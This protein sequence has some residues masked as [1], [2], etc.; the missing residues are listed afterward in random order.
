MALVRRHRTGAQADA[1]A[2]PDR[3][4]Q[5]PCRRAHRRDRGGGYRRDDRGAVDFFVPI[6]QSN[7]DEIAR[8]PAGEFFE[9]LE[10][11][12]I[13]S[14][15]A[16]RI[17]RFRRCLEFDKGAR[18]RA[19]SIKRDIRPADA[20]IQKLR[21]N[22]QPLRY[23]QTR[24]QPLKQLLECRGERCLRNIRV[25]S[26]KLPNSVRV[27]LQEEDDAHGLLPPKLAARVIITQED[28]AIAEI[29]TLPFVICWGVSDWQR[30]STPSPKWAF[31][32]TS[33]LLVRAS[34]VRSGANPAVRL[35]FGRWPGWLRNP[36]FDP[37]D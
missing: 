10:L 7:L 29:S 27:G 24:N 25:R 35:R 8:R 22:G 9:A 20:R 37:I 14:T 3:A 1:A 23:R 17:S 28:H 19:C 33:P 2:V 6:K 15:P 13:R 34:K 26:T 36:K 16:G 21:R 31:H 11:A 18:R 4:R 30:A 5:S 12:C 32:P